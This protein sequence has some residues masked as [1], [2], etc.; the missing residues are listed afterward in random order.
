MKDL[1][2]FSKP[3][4]LV[5]KYY[6]LVSDIPFEIR[7]GQQNYYVDLMYTQ[8]HKKGACTGKHYWLGFLCE[9][10]GLRVIYLTYPFY[11]SELEID[12]PKSLQKLVQKMPLSYHLAIGIQSNNGRKIFLDATWD[13]ALK[14]AGFPVNKI[15]SK[16]VNA[17]NAVALHDE[18]VAHA[19]ALQHDEYIRKLKAK[20]SIKKEE[21]E[22]YTKLNEYLRTIRKSKQP[23]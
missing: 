5:A 17:Q 13:S 2:K 11:W 6:K 19:S 7:L 3:E 23:S 14:K 9:Q 10:L 8:I 20:K 18:P 15:G 12:W 1:R 21:I 4:K 16:L 22:F